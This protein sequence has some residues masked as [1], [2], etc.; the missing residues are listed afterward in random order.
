MMFL[1]SALIALAALTVVDAVAWGGYYRHVF[2][3][4]SAETYYWVKGQDWS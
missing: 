1:K 4:D 2:A 3:H